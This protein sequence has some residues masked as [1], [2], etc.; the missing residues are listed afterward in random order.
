MG[1]SHCDVINGDTQQKTFQVVH[2]D[3]SSVTLINAG[4]R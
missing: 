3:L 2:R 1:C 4:D